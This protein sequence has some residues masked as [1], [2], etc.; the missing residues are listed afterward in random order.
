MSK[1]IMTFLTFQMYVYQFLY[2]F[3][4]KKYIFFTVIMIILLSLSLLLCL[5]S[6]CEIATMNNETIIKNKG[7][8]NNIC[9]N[10]FTQKSRNCIFQ[11]S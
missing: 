1:I 7:R 10:K 5:S 6:L 8:N 2:F 9:E 11:L 4:N 3:T